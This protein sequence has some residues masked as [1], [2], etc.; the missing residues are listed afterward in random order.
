M[1]SSG[2][3]EGIS[4]FDW[5]YITII[6][7]GVGSVQYVGVSNIMLIPNPNTGA[8]NIKGS[9]ATTTD[10]DLAIEVTDMLGQVIYKKQIRSDNGKVNQQIDLGN[11]LANGMYILNISGGNE[12]KSFHFVVE[13]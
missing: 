9:L 11:N 7:T 4:T 3:C 12:N 2:Y 6:P 8:F 10:E 5:V 1:T 13:R